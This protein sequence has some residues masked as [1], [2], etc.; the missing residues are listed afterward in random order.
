MVIPL[1]RTAESPPLEN[2][3]AQGQLLGRRQMER[4]LDDLF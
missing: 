3:P 4:H 1:V 2:E